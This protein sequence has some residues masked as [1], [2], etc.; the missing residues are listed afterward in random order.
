M[1]LVRKR[2]GHVFLKQRGGVTLDRC[3]WRTH[4]MAD[5][6]Q[7]C[8]LELVEFALA[9][10]IAQEQTSPNRPPGLVD[11]IKYP[12]MNGTLAANSSNLNNHLRRFCRLSPCQGLLALRRIHCRSTQ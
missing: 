3:E 9:R 2:P 7:Q 12:Q 6:C 10:H 1:A 8:R 11:H 4:F 5:R